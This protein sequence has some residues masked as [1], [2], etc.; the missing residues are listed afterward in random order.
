M[1]G[2]GI[3]GTGIS[4]LTLALYLQRHGVD[5]TL[6]APQNPG[7][8]RASRLPN[9]VIRFHPAR[10]RER[11]LGVAHWEFAD[12]GASA[13]HL[14]IAGD[15][16]LA[17]TGHLRHQASGVDFRIYLARLLEDYAS[18]GGRVVVGPVGPDDVARLGTTHEL[19]VVASGRETAGLFPRDPHRSPFTAPQ[20]LL[21]AGLYR[22]VALPEPLGVSFN[23]A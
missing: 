15:H 4:G 20:R 12:F 17:F 19:V 6:Y 13:I 22:G 11:L 23:V 8:I 1:A 21:C 2:I 3:V 10:E 16:P 14:S 5:V 9:S 18:R 7:E